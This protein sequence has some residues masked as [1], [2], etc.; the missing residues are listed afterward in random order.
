MPDWARTATGATRHASATP[1]QNDRPHLDR[2]AE[3]APVGAL[4]RPPNDRRRTPASVV[5]CIMNDG[6]SL[7]GVMLTPERMISRSIPDGR[8][9]TVAQVET[10]RTRRGK[11]R[12]LKRGLQPDQ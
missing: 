2:A 10:E 4:V 12:D 1:M 3:A 6:S 11:K 5:G 7:D 9:Q 8:D